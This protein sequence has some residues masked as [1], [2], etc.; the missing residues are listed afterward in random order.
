MTEETNTRATGESEPDASDSVDPHKRKGWPIVLDAD[1]QPR[2]TFERTSLDGVL[3]GR[4]HDRP[5][6]H[7]KEPDRRNQ[8]GPVLA[9]D[10]QLCGAGPFSEERP[11]LFTV[12][13][14]HE[15]QGTDTTVGFRYLALASVTWA[16]FANDARAYARDQRVDLRC[17]RG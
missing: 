11:D 2:V 3:A 8:R 10:S 1:R 14:T 17:V 9:H 15:Q 16:A 4:K 6:T 7:D 5:V 13:R 12:E